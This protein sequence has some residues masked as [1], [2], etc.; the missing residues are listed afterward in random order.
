M[1][2]SRYQLFV[3]FVSTAVLAVIACA[4]RTAA[5]F[6][7]FDRD[8]GYFRSGALL[9]ILYYALAAVSLVWFASFFLRVKKEPPL[10]ELPCPEL[11]TFCGNAISATAFFVTGILLILSARSVSAPLA[12]PV[13]AAVLLLLG[14][15]YFLLPLFGKEEGSALLL[16]GYALIF[17]S[18]L[19]LS[20]TYFDRYTPMNAPHKLAGHL[21]LLSLMLTVLTE[22]RGKLGRR[23]PRAEA[24][25]AMVSF[26][27]CFTSGA[28]GLIAFFGG[29][30]R[31]IVYFAVDLC[32]LAFAV[33]LAVRGAGA[34]ANPTPA[35][36]D[37]AEDPAA[38]STEETE[39]ES[40]AAESSVAESSAAESSAAESST[41]ESS[42][43]EAAERENTPEAA[44]KDPE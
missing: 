1:E 14:C 9:P 30:Y 17:G 28:S 27:L 33:R 21:A 44:K 6:S 40:S 24:V 12:V 4:L 26:F 34:L 2:R 22:L 43:E 8:P 36:A 16:G 5:L 39:A 20:V 23:V 41:A 18:A 19:L 11:S 3:S 10:P 35:P 37:G 25:A 15:A 31:D 38:E 29:V 13:M 42:A 7:A 32:L